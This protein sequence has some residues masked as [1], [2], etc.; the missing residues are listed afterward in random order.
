MSASSDGVAGTFEKDYQWRNLRDAR[1]LARRRLEAV[2]R[3]KLIS[4]S[5]DRKC[6]MYEKEIR[7]CEEL[8][9]VRQLELVP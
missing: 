1:D 7:D 3:M 6:A 4:A 2:Q 5:W 9:Q 8:M